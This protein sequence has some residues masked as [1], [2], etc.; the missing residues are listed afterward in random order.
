[1]HPQSLSTTDPK[2]AVLRGIKD[3]TPIVLGYLPIGFAFGVLASQVGLSLIEATAMSIFVFAGSA[4]L[5][6]VGMIGAGAGM[7]AIVLTTFIVNL[8]HLL[9]SAALVPYLKGVSK[10]KLAWFGYEITDETFALHST[11]F[12]KAVPPLMESFALNGTAHLGWVTGSFLGA[13]A[14][15]LITD[16]QTFGLDFALPAMFIALV[17]MQMQNKTF[18][19]V[20]LFAG[21]AAVIMHLVGFGHWST[22]GATVIAATS[23]VMLERWKSS[24]E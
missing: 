22:I 24:K 15:Q 3:A 13:L 17:L 12:R 18:L 2:A 23:G 6:A 16:V 5:I 19:V 4:Q 8:R 14:G 20:G 9:M 7:L 21:G 10:K 1:M 11:K